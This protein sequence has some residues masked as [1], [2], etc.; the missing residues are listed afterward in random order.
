M[1]TEYTYEETKNRTLRI[2]ACSGKE[3]EITIPAKLGGKMVTELADYLFSPHKEAGKG[4]E[5]SENY[6]RE[7]KK[8][9]LPGT[10]EKIGD[11]AFYGCSNLETLSFTDRLRDVGGGA[12]T[13][14]HPKEVVLDFYEGE[15][16]VLKEVTGEI[17]Q[18]VKA[19]LRYHRGREREEAVLLFPEYYEEAVENTPARLLST[20]FH[21]S[22]G[23]YRQCFQQRAV[24]YKEYD[25]LFPLAKA[26]EAV[27]ET[28]CL[29]YWRLR[30][31]YRLSDEAKEV[32]KSYLSDMTEMVTA[33]IIGQE[34]MEMLT[35]MT[36]EKYWN[37]QSIEA[38]IGEAVRMQNTVCTGYLMEVKEKL[39]QIEKK[40]Y[41]W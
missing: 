40:K 23:N 11:Y 10:L 5:E 3:Q 27:W 2:T 35:F 20:R 16:S 17:R 14:C 37:N 41:T 38:A 19:V 30:Y 9:F 8:V 1:K 21:G 25:M 33:E 36:A 18:S 31:P 7:L 6:G 32:Y 12:F 4:S 34:H 13:G 15:T 29:A 26:R 28:Y 39:F 22:G 24:D